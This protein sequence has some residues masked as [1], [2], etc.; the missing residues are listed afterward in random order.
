[1]LDINRIRNNPQEVVDA[2][3]KKG[4][5]A[6]FT[7]ILKWDDER[8]KTITEIEQLKAQKNKVSS[9]I[10]MLKKAGQSVEP[11]FEEMKKMI[12]LFLSAISP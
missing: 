4:Y 9:Q 2:L 12:S 3:A 8:K 10:P 11:I 1:M 5:A 6:D 7:E